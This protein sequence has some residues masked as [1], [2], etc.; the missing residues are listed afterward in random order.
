MPLQHWLW[1]KMQVSSAK[2]N[3]D[4]KT[5]NMLVIVAKTSHGHK[6]FQRLGAIIQTRRFYKGAETEDPVPNFK[7][8]NSEQ[9]RYIS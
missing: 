1:G 5:S 9:L 7:M 3:Q 6:K 2:F 8:Q 4:E